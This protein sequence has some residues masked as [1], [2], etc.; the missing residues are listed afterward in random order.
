MH[1][2]KLESSTERKKEAEVFGNKERP[3]K[4]G[5]GMLK[6]HTTDE[7]THKRQRIFVRIRPDDKDESRH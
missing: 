1:R 2:D 7:K 3:R 4:R 5:E 6:K